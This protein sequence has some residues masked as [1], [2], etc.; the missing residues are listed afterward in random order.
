ME[1]IHFE[2]PKFWCFKTFY[3][4]LFG[5]FNAPELAFTALYRAKHKAAQLSSPWPAAA[6]AYS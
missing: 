6:V 4:A 1:P 3:L 5:Y 2:N